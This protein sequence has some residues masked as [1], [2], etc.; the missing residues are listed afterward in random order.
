LVASKHFSSISRGKL[1]IF[2]Y[3]FIY[4]PADCIELTMK[5]QRRNICYF[6]Q[7]LGVK[8]FPNVTLIPTI[9]N[10][11]ESFFMPNSFDENDVKFALCGIQWNSYQ[12]H[13]SYSFF[14]ICPL[15]RS[16]CSI[17]LKKHSLVNFLYSFII[18]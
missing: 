17:N 5:S 6:I 8:P 13:L 4:V 15:D 1:N 18:S 12:M 16:I 7:S 3:S 2:G 9:V 10:S 11:Y 14:F